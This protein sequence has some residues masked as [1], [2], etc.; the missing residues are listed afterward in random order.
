LRDKVVILED[1]KVEREREIGDL[2]EAVDSAEAEKRSI[3]EQFEAAQ[4]A[5]K[6]AETE[7]AGEAFLDF[8]LS[9]VLAKKKCFA[10][11]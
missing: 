6:K 4:G 9:L 11:L 5:L 3:L 2:R 1:E 7:V 8:R 10:I